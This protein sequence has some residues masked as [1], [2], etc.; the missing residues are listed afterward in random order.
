MTRRLSGAPFSRFA[1][2]TCF[3]FILML[4]PNARVVVGNSVAMATSD[5]D[6]IVRSELLRRLFYWQCEYSPLSLKHL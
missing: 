6:F 5:L 1:R 2:K 3:E 4:T